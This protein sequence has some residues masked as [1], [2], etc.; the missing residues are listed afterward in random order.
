MDDREFTQLAG[1]LGSL[2]AG[3]TGAALAPDGDRFRSGVSTGVGSALGA[4]LGGLGGAGVGGAVGLGLG[5]LTGRLLDADKFMYDAMDEY[6]LAGAM[7]GSGLG[8]TL[9]GV[10]GSSVGAGKGYDVARNKTSSLNGDENMSNDYT[11]KVA[12]AAGAVD[13][14]RRNGISPNR[15]LYTALQTG[16]PGLMKV[17]GIIAEGCVIGRSYD[18]QKTAG[19]RDVAGAVG[20]KLKSLLGRGGEEAVGE[21]AEEID[22]GMIERFLQSISEHGGRAM[23]TARERGGQ[24]FDYAT[25]NS[26]RD[27]G[28]DL[29]NF[30]DD[31]RNRA[32]DRISARDRKKELALA[33]LAGGGGGAALGAGGMYAA[34]PEDSA[35]NNLR[36]LVGM[37]QTSRLGGLLG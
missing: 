33:A 4:G 30:S 25:S 21:A 36:G 3:V 22:P 24:A 28:A 13:T 6:R 32:A 23:D 18:F 26:V 37:D 15:F 1:I 20:G 35:M 16:D 12:Y 8:G 2:P 9:G 29:R 7:L 34:G 5:E 14:L 19:V 27:M 31:V 17:A 11:I 10:L